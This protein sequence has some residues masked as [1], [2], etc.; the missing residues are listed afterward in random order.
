M[1]RCTWALR[2][3]LALALLAGG[4]YWFTPVPTLRPVASFPGEPSHVVPCDI[5]IFNGTTLYD[6]Q[7]VSRWRIP[8]PSPPILTP[9]MQ[10]LVVHRQRGQHAL[11]SNG[12]YL[13]QIFVDGRKVG[14]TLYH[15]GDEVGRH[16][17]Y[18]VALF[19]DRP[20]G[21]AD[22]WCIHV[23]DDGAVWVWLYRKYPTP[24]FLLRGARVVA[25][26]KLPP[27]SMLTPDGRY[28]AVGLP[29]GDGQF[30]RTIV[31]QRR[32]TFTKLITVPRAVH[33]EM[34]TTPDGKPYLDIEPARL[35]PDHVW[36]A[37][38]KWLYWPTG[39][40]RR[41]DF[42]LSRDCSNGRQIVDFYPTKLTNE[43]RIVHP[44]TGKGWS[45]QASKNDH[46]SNYFH[47]ID[48]NDQYAL[49]SVDDD[50]RPMW[51][52]TACM[53]LRHYWVPVRLPSD[54][55]TFKLYARS[56]RLV[57]QYRLSKECS[58]C[59]DRRF[60]LSPDGRQVYFVNSA[61]NLDKSERIVLLR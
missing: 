46:S 31:R 57:A 2:I 21:F 43:V 19:S 52:H 9:A 40:K 29:S 3:G 5:G 6:W 56:G 60:Y 42:D 51:M 37:C 11:S 7:G 61:P 34:R 58:C 45:L 30:Y 54:K 15:R 24:A 39:K 36:H 1:T 18:D 22:P 55:T 50:E 12:D 53:W 25:T 14:V 35:Y 4:W 33:T 38:D 28:L 32:L 44:A 17:L 41:L 20:P 26:G 10:H 23:R 59:T 48:A 47:S 13:A 16:P 8:L 27:Y 49:V